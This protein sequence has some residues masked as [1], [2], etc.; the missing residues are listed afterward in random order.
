MAR[1]L[2]RPARSR[3][4]GTIGS[5]LLTRFGRRDRAQSPLEL[6]DA[7]VRPRAGTAAHDDDRDAHG[8][9]DEHEDQ[10]LHPTSVPAVGAVVASARIGCAPVAQSEP[11]AQCSCFQ[12][13]TLAFTRSIAASAAAKAVPRCG[14]DTTTATAVSLS[15]SR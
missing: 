6:V 4:V 9:R 12:I 10:E 13:G 3:A 5:R 8:A 14:L 11:A 7:R 15:S 1:S 2:A